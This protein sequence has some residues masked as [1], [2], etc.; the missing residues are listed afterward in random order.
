MRKKINLQLFAE[1]VAPTG[2]PTEAPIAQEEPVVQEPTPAAQ[3]PRSTSDRLKSLWDNANAPAQPVTENQQNQVDNPAN[4][5]PKA[6]GTENEPP[7]AD[8]PETQAQPNN[9]ILGKYET[10]PDLI[11]A[12][13]NIQTAYNKDHQALID[14]QKIIEQLKAES[15]KPSIPDEQTDD[16]LEGLDDEALLEK[17]YSGPKGVLQKIVEK[18]LG[19]KIKEVE[20]KIAPIIERE[21]AQA[22]TDAW[23]KAAEEFLAENADMKDYLDGMKQYIADNNLTD[24]D[25]PHSVIKAAYADAKAKAADAK[26]A[27]AQKEI[28]DL[29]AQL[30][31]STED[32]INEY[33]G[34][35]RNSQTNIAN[36]IS[37]N[38]N[39][40]AAAMPPP[41]LKGKSISELTKA[42]GDFIF[43][44]RG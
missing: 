22:N 43:G 23:S 17:F 24:N 41:N 28:A 3:E 31:K 5:A 39:S 14:S 40:G 27:A 6:E 38:S 7:K 11:K 8:N 9:K 30:Q 35:V 36:A 10:V 2:T 18:T 32:T 42:A 4:Q 12:Y 33:L 16:D 13:Q 29:K 15:Q 20:S 1:P 25:N 26:I 21:K 34:K 44:N 37:G 19:S